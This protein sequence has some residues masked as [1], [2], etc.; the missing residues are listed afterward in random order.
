MQ[1]DEKQARVFI[2][3]DHP[4][5]RQGIVKLI[6][7]EPGLAVCGDSGDVGA[8]LSGI[9]AEEPDVAIVDLSLGSG[10]GIDLIKRVH[11]QVPKV[12]FLVLT[13]HDDAL[14]LERAVRAGAR[15]FVTKQE[16]AAEILIALREVLEGRVYLS[17]QVSPKL[18]MRLI[19]SPGTDNDTVVDRLSDRELQVLRLIGQGKATKEIAEA[20]HLSVKTVESY[21]ANIK[22]KLELKDALDLVRYAMRWVL[23]GEEK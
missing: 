12:R 3:D 2:V 23:T 5:V 4:I 20:L 17:R 10:D 22:E 21:R 13:M 18:L 1:S 9:I 11:A 15:G 8:A 6:A 14:H 19:Q 7:D 16:V